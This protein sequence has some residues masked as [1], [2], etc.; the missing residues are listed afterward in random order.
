MIGFGVGV[1]NM[2]PA[3]QAGV[4]PIA[5]GTGYTSTKDMLIWGGIFAVISIVLITSVGYPLAK[6]IL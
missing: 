5:I 1:S 2:T 6:A 3:G 4:N